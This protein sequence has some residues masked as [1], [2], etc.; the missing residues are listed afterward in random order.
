VM[1]SLQVSVDI[2]HLWIGDLLVSLIPPTGQ[3]V[4]LHNREGGDTDNIRRVY[5]PSEVPG[6]AVLLGNRQRSSGVWRLK[7]AD[8]GQGH[9]GKLSSWSL[10]IETE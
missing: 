4:M 9:T 8:V 5:T 7:V 2:S 10:L 1:K 3:E 6:L